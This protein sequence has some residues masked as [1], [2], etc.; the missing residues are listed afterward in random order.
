M[1]GEYLLVPYY[2]SYRTYSTY[3]LFFHRHLDAYAEYPTLV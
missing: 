2:V 1:V 3:H